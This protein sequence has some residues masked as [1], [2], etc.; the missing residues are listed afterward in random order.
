M[1][2]RRRRKDRGGKHG[3]EPRSRLQLR[4]AQVLEQLLVGRTQHQIAEALGIS[5]PG[6]SKIV[7]RAEEKLLTD[8][9]YK[10]ERQRARQTLRLEHIYGQAMHAWQDSKQEGLRR[11]QRKTE[12]ESGTGSTVAELI[13]E[14]RHGDPRY[15]DEARKALT[16]MR[17]VWGVDAPERVSIDAS[18]HYASMSDDALEA[19]LVRHVRLLQSS[20][21][22]ITAAT[23]SPEPKGGSDEP[24]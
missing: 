2:V 19:E 9:A 8:F 18:T 20:P 3:H 15:L 6:V 21:P 16:D 1:T 13:S 12:H 22:E 11:R 4:E 10:T 14:N 24:K 5:Q 7:R 23:A 17:K